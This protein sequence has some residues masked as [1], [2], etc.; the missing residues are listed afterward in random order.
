MDIK[1]LAK[2]L[3]ILLLMTFVFYVTKP[4][5]QLLSDKIITNLAQSRVADSDIVIV[6]IDDYSLWKLQDEW[7]KWPWNRSIHAF[8]LE[9]MERAQ[10]K[11]IAYDI[12]F[13]Q[14]DSQ[15][16][17]GDAYGSHGLN[18]QVRLDYSGVIAD[19]GRRPER[20]TCR[21]NHRVQ[22]HLNWTQIDDQLGA[23]IRL[24]QVPI[25]HENGAARGLA[26]VTA[27][28]PVRVCEDA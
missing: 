25:V 19:Y 9:E 3:L 13:S 7:G 8:L 18:L 11:V 4:A 12:I 1:L 10:A 20:L 6:T 22:V 28:R 26:G 5:N 2:Y 23:A 27:A 14:P 21:T 15:N 16:P 17:D 24:D